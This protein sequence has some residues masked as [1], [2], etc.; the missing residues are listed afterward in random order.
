MKG[1]LICDTNSLSSVVSRA[2]DY[3]TEVMGKVAWL[4]SGRAWISPYAMILCAAC[5]SKGHESPSPY[6]DA[7]P[8]PTAPDD[9]ADSS[10]NWLES[11][12]QRNTST[13]LRG[14][15]EL[16]SNR[17]VLT[18]E[19]SAIP[20][21][22][23]EELIHLETPLVDEA[24]RMSGDILQL[25]AEQTFSIPDGIELHG[26]TAVII[27]GSVQVGEGG[28]QIAA[29][30]T[31]RIEGTIESAGPIEVY[32]TEPTGA[33]SIRGSIQSPYISILGRGRIQMN[34][35]ITLSP[36]QAQAPSLILDTY[37]DIELG[38][39][40]RI[41][42]EGEAE[43]QIQTAGQ[44]QFAPNALQTPSSPRL[45]WS[46]EAKL[47]HMLNNFSGQLGSFH[48]TAEETIQFENNTKLEVLGSQFVIVGPYI[49]LG[50]STAFTNLHPAPR[51]YL[52]ARNQLVV[53][54]NVNITAIPSECNKASPSIQVLA[55]LYSGEGTAFFTTTS[56][57]STEECSTRV[58][59]QDLNGLAPIITPNMDI[60][61]E[62]DL[63]FDPPLLNTRTYGQWRSEPFQVPAGTYVNLDP[64]SITVPFG[65]RVQVSMATS[66]NSSSVAEDFLNPDDGMWQIPDDHSWAVISIE[67]DGLRY[68]APIVDQISL[69]WP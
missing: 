64:A 41:E 40:L 44:V 68:D 42:T 58:A 46:V 11:F 53:G 67:L 43:I 50:S 4:L 13:K 17:G 51:V 26:Q 33:V 28:I 20:N 9:S 62:P 3:I 55:G 19:T 15:A 31:V 14:Q 27:E 30:E 39:D 35:T 36:Q 6:N 57:V 48:M 12:D 45:H 69:T 5:A 24:G 63:S 29:R 1:R 54:Q 66:N 38:P 22:E 16:D 7:S 32:I 52:E 37:G 65:T 47:I 61:L 60:Q 8:A 23:G 2:L 49:N 59:A 21:P 25:A 56:T 18:L 10:P 34:G